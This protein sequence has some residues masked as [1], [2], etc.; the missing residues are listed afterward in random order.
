MSLQ[1]QFVTYEIALKLKELGFDEPCIVYYNTKSQE[2]LCCCQLGGFINEIEEEDF[3]K[4]SIEDKCSAPLYS[5]I[6]DWLRENHGKHIRIQEG[7][8]PS[9]HYYEFEIPWK[10]FKTYHQ[11]RE[12]V[13]LRLLQNI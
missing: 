4:N 13:I 1:N 3:H 6:E 11:A 10:T 5:Q 2:S 9:K 8:T 7:Y 12:H